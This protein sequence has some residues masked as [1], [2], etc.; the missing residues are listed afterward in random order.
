MK[1]WNRR[2]RVFA[3]FLLS[4][5]LLLAVCTAG[6]LCRESAAVTDFSRTNLA[7]CIEYPFGTDWLGRDMLARTLRGLS[8]S[9]QLGFLAAAVSTGM[10]FLLGTI[11]AVCGKTA[12][13]VVSFLIDLAM[14]IPHIL[15]MILISAAAGKGFKGVVLAVALTH[16]QAL[17]RLVRAEVLKIKESPYIQI[18]G[19]LG[20]SR[21]YIVRKHIF[22]QLFSQLFT[23]LV[24]LFP[25]AILHEA[26]ITFLG[27]GLSPEQPAV[28]IILSEAMKYLLMGKWWLAL[29]PGA[30]LVIVVRLFYLAGESVGKLTEPGSIHE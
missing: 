4:V 19:K 29:F 7:P 28:G 25:A 3:G 11:S 18:A 22:P 5:L 1:H 10:A 2:Q 23:G 21:W 15:L 14:G 16:W 6:I 20:K 27:F 9:I 24:L 13:T 30:M 26:S 12:D 8:I 17:A